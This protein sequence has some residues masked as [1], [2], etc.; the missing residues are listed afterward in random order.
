MTRTLVSVIMP[1]KNAVPYVAEAVRSVLTQ[2]HADLE[3]LVV[4]D[5]SND[6]SRATVENINDDRLRV[7]DG[8]QAGIAMAFNCGLR[9][10]SGSVIARCDADDVYPP[11]RLTWQVQ[12]LTTHA[13]FGAVC[14][15]FTSI[16]RNGRFVRKMAT[17]V[18][19]EEITE[20]LRQGHARTSA[21]TYAVRVDALREVGGCREYFKVGEDLDLQYRLARVCRVWYE[22]ECVYRYRLHDMSTTHQRASAERLFY[23]EIASRF[24]E[25]RERTGCDDL[26]RGC[27]P[28][29]PPRS[30][31]PLGANEH[32]QDL[33]CGRAWNHH[34][35]G[36]RWQALRV[37]LSACL[38]RPGN[39][40]AW[41]SLGALVV[42]RSPR[43]AS[44]EAD[45]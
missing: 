38:Y 20:E 39:L 21:C 30:S 4:D 43:R 36:H 29:A 23:Q 34:R 45:P 25:Q 42:K 41:K 31:A 9:A 13:A 6:G 24:A 3:L 12:W 16:D 19:S 32:I 1:L 8:P 10:A 28:A 7:L 18:R 2:D 5:G 26:E 14:G 40:A 17:H 35:D 11:G 15:G 33:L 37:G 44:G 22:P 27:P